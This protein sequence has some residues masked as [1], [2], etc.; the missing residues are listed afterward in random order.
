MID[1]D[2]DR[3]AQERRANRDRRAKLCAELKSRLGN[4]R[5][6]DARDNGGGPMADVT[7]AKTEQLKRDI[8]DCDA[9]D[10]QLHAALLHAQ[11]Q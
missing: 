7:D 5:I 3:L 4:P 6:R 8:A 9:R 11:S 10:A 1:V 2:D